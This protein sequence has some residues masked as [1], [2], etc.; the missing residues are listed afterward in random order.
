MP[1][2]PGRSFKRFFFL[3]L[4]VSA[5]NYSCKKEDC[6]SIFNNHLLVGFYETDTLE[7]GAVD[8][9]PK[10]TLFY[11]VSA[12]GNDS[13]FYGPDKTVSV[14]TLPVD[15]AGATTTFELFMVESVSY[16]TISKDPLL[17]EA[18]Y[19]PVSTPHI[20]EVSY[21]RSTRIITEE[22][23]VEIAFTGLTIGEITFPNYALGEGVLSRLQFDNEDRVNIEVYF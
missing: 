8:I 2:N 13:I 9:I 6:V 23:A 4:I 5:F 15:P 17:V 12:P 1:L 19:T 14:L 22:C 10:D 11:Q 20:I 16:D 18:T 21:D 3:F 7:S